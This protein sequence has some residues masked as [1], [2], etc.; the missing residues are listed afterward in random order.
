MKLSARNRFEGTVSGIKSGAVNDE[1]EIT[2]ADGGLRVVA[3]IT[4]ESTTNLGLAIGKPATAWVKAPSVT[5]AT[6]DVQSHSS[7]RNRFVGTVR[8]VRQGAVNSEVT[9]AV[10]GGTEVVAIVTCE[11][12][13]RLGLAVG[14]PAT[15]L[16]KAPS[17]IVGVPD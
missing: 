15:V 10:Q 8:R 3:I 7:A 2:T 5:V 11:S 6:G 14:T 1:I 12:A 4:H 16:F 9:V 17:V 13:E